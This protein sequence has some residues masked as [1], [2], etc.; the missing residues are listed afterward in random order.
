MIVGGGIGGAVLALLLGRQ[1]HRVVVL[2]RDATPS[3]IG[4]PEVLA[5]STL[6]V[7][8]QLGLRLRMMQDAVV[9]LQR[10]E[11]RQAGGRR[12]VEFTQDDF[13]RAG[14]QPYSTDPVRTRQILLEAAASTHAVEVRRGV[15]VQT[16]L[17]D[18][19]RITGVRAVGG[20][21]P[22]S[23]GAR[24]VVGDDGGC[25]RV[26][27][28][29]GIPLAVREFAVDFLA[30]AGP[31]LPGHEAGVGQAWLEPRGLRRGIFGAVFMPLP[32]E[33]TA[34]AF[35]LSPAA[36]RRYAAGA[37]S[38]FYEAA[39][40][41]APRCEGLRR[42]HRFP[43]GLAHLRRPFGHAPRYVGDGVA[44]MG[45]AAH[46]VTPAGGQG[47]NMSVADAVALAGVAHDALARGDCSARH[48]QAYETQRRPANDRS[49]QIS[50]RTQ[51]VLRGLGAL[52][53]L[54]VFLPRFLMRVNRRETK[55]RLLRAV[56][57]AFVSSATPAAG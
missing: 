50:A 10:M 44:L 13:R 39:A 11:L 22:F 30:A 25:S 28:A 42:V 17:R 2:E 51:W 15:E 20:T 55:D 40:R 24:L 5:R 45:D 33:R 48:L 43:E 54:A 16:L 32:G 6:Q 1:G 57:Q 3:G 7:F 38:R 21:A 29:L 19:A 56:S 14:V 18:G 37:P 27:E 46:P 41:L 49:V 26:R 23:W 8:E 53:W 12:L 4:R 47:A 9:P 35:L 34:L 31:A 36:Y 52:P